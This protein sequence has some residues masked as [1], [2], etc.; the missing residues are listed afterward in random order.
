MTVAADEIAFRRATAED[1]VCVVA[2]FLDS[3]RADW[4]SGLVAFEDW[5]PLMEPQARKIFSRPGAVV[6]VAYAPA[7][8]VGHDIYGWL[9]HETGHRWPYVV[10][11]YVKELYRR[12]GVARMLFREAGIDPTKPLHHA[13]WLAKPLVAKVSRGQW[14]PLTIRERVRNGDQQRR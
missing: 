2:N 10:Y 11:C 6:L 4:T 13:T 5:W 14:D 1:M 3:T 7:E 12:N 8:P 9:A